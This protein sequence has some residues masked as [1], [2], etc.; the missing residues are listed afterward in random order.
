MG[1]VHGTKLGLGHCTGGLGLAA[2]KGHPCGSFGPAPFPE[3]KHIRVQFG[4]R[5]G[6][7]NLPTVTVRHIGQQLQY[8]EDL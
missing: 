6:P 7:D 4:P 1:T 2:I 8:S 5:Q 3:V